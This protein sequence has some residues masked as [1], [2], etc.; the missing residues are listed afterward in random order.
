MTENTV[1][2]AT[3]NDFNETDQWSASVGELRSTLYQNY[4]A[5]A[6]IL[7]IKEEQI[8]SADAL[9]DD[10]LDELYRRNKADLFDYYCRYLDLRVLC[11]T[12]VLRRDTRHQM[13]R[14][15]Q[16]AERI[17]KQRLHR[18]LVDFHMWIDLAVKCRNARRIV[19]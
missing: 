13:R 11:V 18:K 4:L 2:E 1:T 15:L 3:F 16:K 19:D 8:T 7:W 6:L 5:Q 12:D 17:P 14:L 10:I 9:L